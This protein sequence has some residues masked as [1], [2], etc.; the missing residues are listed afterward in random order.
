MKGKA[1]SRLLPRIALVC[2]AL[3]SAVW[4]AGDAAHQARAATLIT[5][6]TC[7]AP[8]LVATIDQANSD[9]AGDTITFGC[10]GD[11]ALGDN[12]WITGSMTLDGNGRA[13]TLDGQQRTQVV[14]VYGA[15]N[16]TFRN[17]TIANGQTDP[18]QGEGGGGIANIGGTVSVINSTLS[19]NNAG[20]FLGGGIYM[21][22]GTVNVTNSTLS[23]NWGA[24]D[25]GGIYMYGGTV[26]V[27]NSILSGNRATDNGSGIANAW[28]TLSVT[29]STFSNNTLQGISCGDG[30]G[31]ENNG[32]L[33]V[34]NSTFSNN[35]VQ[36]RGS[37]NCLGGGIANE[38]GTMTVTNSTF[39]ANSV[40]ANSGDGGAIWNAWGANLSLTNSTFG[41][42]SAPST[43]GV[44]N[45]GAATMSN[46]IL[47]QG[48]SGANCDNFGTLTDKGGNLSTDSSCGGVTQV[49]AAALNLGALADNNGQVAGAPGSSAAVQTIAPLPGS[50]AIDFAG[51][52]CPGTDERGV[53]RLDSGESTCDSGAYEFVDPKLATSTGLS[54]SA[55]PSVQGQTVTFTA[56]VRAAVPGTGTPTGTVTFM[57][58][59]TTMGSGAINGSGV[60]T[61]S[62]SLSG[63]PHYLTA[64]YGGDAPFAG[65]TSNQLGLAVESPTSLFT[66]QTPTSI[67]RGALE[68]GVSFKSTVAGHIIGLRYYRVA[69]E[70]G[71]HIGHLWSAGGT[72][73][74]SVTF[75]NE[76][77]SGWQYALFASPIAISALTT[78]VA[79]VNCNTLFGVT[80]AGLSSVVVHG[81]LIGEGGVETGTVGTFPNTSTT[82]NYFR[83]V[84]FTTA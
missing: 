7:D 80:P 38:S 41:A 51:A 69:G 65:S 59:A 73:L 46:T 78:Y 40:T 5:V 76:T 75:T 23:G 49:S 54:S 55:N 1:M 72:L 52:N 35:R 4:W 10:S 30:G 82:T 77:A 28:S 27:T 56:S 45:Y 6:S 44:A 11:I 68:L 33:T 66:T 48:A 37:Y 29:N 36:S 39:S 24:T 61:Y 8:H 17:L 47:A 15:V 2:S 31:I 12:L 19:N 21:S 64:V 63:G 43:G 13:V 84:L 3:L 81:P 71:T 58:G 50:A 42:N 16:V 34:S 53:A 70:T 83:D 57:D 14:Y 60:A 62:T 9:N 32:T 79:S 26:N 20:G 67:M 25:G 74:G 18:G 22:T